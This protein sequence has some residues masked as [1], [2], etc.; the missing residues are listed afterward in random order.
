MEE[1]AEYLKGVKCS[2]TENPP[3]RNI[4]RATTPLITAQAIKRVTNLA[5]SA[6]LLDG[7]KKKCT[8]R[9]K[10]EKFQFMA[11][12]FKK[13]SD[14]GKKARKRLYHNSSESDSSLEEK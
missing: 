3:E 11:K 7:H 4:I 13:A 14:K 10:K 8:D 1:L 12:A 6:S 2:E 9:A 5:C